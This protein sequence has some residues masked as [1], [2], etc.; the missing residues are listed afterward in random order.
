MYSVDVFNVR[1]RSVNLPW[2]HKPVI[3]AT[4]LYNV[5]RAAHMNDRCVMGVDVL[6]HRET[7]HMLVDVLSYILLCDAKVKVLMWKVPLLAARFV[8]VR[9]LPSMHFPI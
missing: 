7:F 4:L 9:E 8:T 2:R 1:Q 6:Y 3:L 5:Q